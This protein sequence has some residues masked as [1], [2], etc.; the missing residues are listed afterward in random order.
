MMLAE[1]GIPLVEAHDLI[2][3]DLDGVVYVGHQVVPHAASS[4]MRAR[5]LGAHIAFVTNNA[6]RT[7]V[8]VAEHLT[9]LGI[10]ARADDVVTSAQAAARLLRERLPEGSR[11]YVIGGEGLE[12]AL[13]ESGLEPVFD[14]EDGA[15]AVVQGY[16]PD[17]PWR[18]VVAGAILVKSGHYWVASNM[19]RTIPTSLGVGPGNGAL[20]ELVS[21]YSGKVPV[22]A[23]KPEPPLLREVERRT[24]ARRPLFVGDRLDTDMAGAANVGWPSLLVRTGVT[25]LHDLVSASPEERPTYIAADL[26][27]LH[28]AHPSPRPDGNAWVLGGWR[29]SVGD[30]A[31]LVVDGGGSDDDWWRCAASA[32]WS[33]R[34]AAEGDAQNTVVRVDDVR[35]PR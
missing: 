4:L 20:V 30:D 21:T 26:N 17:M 15:D 12:V 34:D 1:S 29:A 22:V 16:G 23:G 33:Y 7:P 3:L 18:R 31:H 19:D 25:T 28:D 11:V 9:L 27:G 10:D 6:A 8:A 24:E 13:R 32:A 2:A 14:A 5:E 35:P